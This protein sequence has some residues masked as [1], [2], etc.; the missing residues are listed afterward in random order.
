MYLKEIEEKE[1][2]LQIKEKDMIVLVIF[3]SFIL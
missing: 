3:K 2:L 1:K